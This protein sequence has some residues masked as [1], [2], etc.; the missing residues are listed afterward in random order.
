MHAWY[1]TII[2]LR[3][4]FKTISSKIFVD[5]NRCQEQLVMLVKTGSEIKN[6]FRTFNKD[7]KVDSES[8]LNECSCSASVG[9]S[10]VM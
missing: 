5:N 9:Y 10:S 1:L 4:Y 8:K 2:L 6:N 7:K 3:G